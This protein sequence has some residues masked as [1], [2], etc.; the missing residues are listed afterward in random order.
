M[1][2][3]TQE[4][5]EMLGE[6]EIEAAE[7]AF[8]EAF[9]VGVSGIAFE[10]GPQTKRGIRAAVEAV[11]DMEAPASE[12]EGPCSTCGDGGQD[13]CSRHRPAPVEQPAQSGASE[14]AYNTQF[15]GVTCKGCYA[16][17]SACGHCARC[18]KERREMRAEG[19]STP[20]H[21]EAMQR[22]APQDRPQAPMLTPQPVPLVERKD[23]LVEWTAQII[24]NWQRACEDDP[25]IVAEALAGELVS[26]W[27]GVPAPVRAPSAPVDPA[28]RVTVKD[29]M[30][31][32]DGIPEALFSDRS[33]PDYKTYDV[34]ARRYAAGFRVEL[35]RKDVQP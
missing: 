22:Y 19:E 17:G 34:A 6:R 15:A 1:S 29:G 35:S 11:L 27:L 26:M 14:E 9:L 33:R 7:Q 24:R 21:E 23:R 20:S 18:I 10:L 5:R 2:K 4:H 13:M 16:L 28:E 3:L 31:Y 32:L 30:V 8:Q 12:P 25:K